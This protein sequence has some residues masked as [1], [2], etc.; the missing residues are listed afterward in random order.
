MACIIKLP[1]ETKGIISFTSPESREVIKD[2]T[3]KYLQQNRKD[4]IY[5]LHHN[6]QP[7]RHDSFYDS[8][9]CNPIDLQGG[10]NCLG[11]DCCNFSPE[12]YRPS[13][14]KSFDVLFVT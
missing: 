8:S 6:W 11:M 13:N 7:C 9:L 14:E 1:N 10:G 4:W 2:E 12:L 5:L 3:L